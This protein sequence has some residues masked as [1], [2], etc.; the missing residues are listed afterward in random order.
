MLRVDLKKQFRTNG[1]V[2]GGR[3]QLREIP[4]PSKK[5]RDAF[6]W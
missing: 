3:Y 5:V 6:L 4:P 2:I 1:R